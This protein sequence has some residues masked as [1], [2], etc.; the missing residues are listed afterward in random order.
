MSATRRRQDPAAQSLAPAPPQ[1]LLQL[2]NY[3]I[4]GYWRPAPLLFKRRRFG[5][6]GSRAQC[7]NGRGEEGG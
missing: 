1:S 4:L 7:S 2:N 6:G 5:T 3:H